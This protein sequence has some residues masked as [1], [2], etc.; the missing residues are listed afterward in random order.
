MTAGTTL[1]GVGVGRG[2]VVGPVARV[3]SVPKPPADEKPPTD[4]D[5]AKSSVSAA[6]AAVATGLRERAAESSGT[7]STVL[8]ATALMAE[9]KALI[10]DILKRIDGGEPTLTAVDR[11]VEGFCDM[12]KSLGDYLAERVTDLRSVRGR[13]LARLMG[14]AEPEMPDLSV[15]SVIVAED[16]APADTAALDLAKVLAVVTELGGPTSHTAII[17]GQHGIPCVVRVT[18]VMAL[19]DGQQVAVDAAAGTIELDPSEATKQLFTDRSELLKSLEENTAP[20]ATSDGHPV[21]L[22][23]NIGQVEDAKRAAKRANEGVGLFRTE[24]LFLD[25]KEAPPREGQAATY[26]EVLRAFE[27]RKVV[28]RTLDAGADKPLAFATQPDEENPALGVR[29]YRLGRITPSLMETQL[30]AL[31]DAQEATGIY[32]WVMAPMIAT[33]AEAQAFA[34]QARAVGIKTVGVMIEIPSAAVRA[35]QIVEVVDFVSIGTNDL[36]QYT[37][38]ADRLRGELA[39]LLNPWQP[40]VLELVARVAAAGT[41]SGTPVGVCGES[42]ADPLMALVLAG[43]GV[44][45]LSMSPAAVATARYMLSKHTMDWCRALAAAALEADSADDARAAVVSRI[46]QKVRQLLAL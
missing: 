40:A 29:G 2:A 31:A 6:F 33:K 30:G 11:S 14:Q 17:A 38:A 18:G 16:L 1:Q 34:D 39:D 25:S 23:A 8:S 22:L 27:G 42:A 4:K 5:A 19:E 9:D 20:G 41:R 26:A 3:S 44:S 43:F 12:F 10:K 45:S 37:M 35:E 13:V 28:V 36:A 24:V 15:P 32:P 46:D 7:L 21:Q